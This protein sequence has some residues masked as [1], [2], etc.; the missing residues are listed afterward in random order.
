MICLHFV[1]RNTMPRAKSAA[2]KRRSQKFLAGL[3]DESETP[4]GSLAQQPSVAPT[5]LAPPLP[6]H[7]GPH[8]RR[9]GATS[10]IN[11]SQPPVQP[12]PRP[13]DPQL[14]TSRPS[15]STSSFHLQQQGPPM[16]QRGPTP[17]RSNV[18]NEQGVPEVPNEE[19]TVDKLISARTGKTIAQEEAGIN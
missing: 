5:T 11:D 18:T 9:Q 2:G 4:E 14:S 10:R 8:D 7:S 16:L 17:T 15:S 1:G 12:S 6:T 3:L 19:F 13:S